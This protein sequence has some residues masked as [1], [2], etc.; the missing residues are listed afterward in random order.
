MKFVKLQES[1]NLLDA[2]AEL[3]NVLR[4]RRLINVDSEIYSAWVNLKNA[5]NQEAKRDEKIH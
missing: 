4:S 5:I 3:V 1:P 2:A